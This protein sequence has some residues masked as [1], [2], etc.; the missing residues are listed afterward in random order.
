MFFHE[1][2]DFRFSVWLIH[3]METLESIDS[4]ES[5]DSM[6]SMESMESIESEVKYIRWWYGTHVAPMGSGPP[7]RYVN[8]QDRSE[9]HVTGERIRSK[10]RQAKKTSSHYPEKAHYDQQTGISTHLLN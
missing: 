6:E 3:S 2:P 1:N 10:L 8:F 7:V 5:V 4:M 9:N